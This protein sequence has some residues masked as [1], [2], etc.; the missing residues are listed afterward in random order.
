M[1]RVV[2]LAVAVVLGGCLL[3]VPWSQARD[4]KKAEKK[5]LSAQEFVTKASA[6]GLAEVNLSGLAKDRASRAEVKHFAE[7]MVT[8]HTKANAELLQL[9]NTKSLR[10]AP[11]M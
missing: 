9:A 3:A 4:E 10:V 1:R 6:A 2:S 5:A 7:H 8:D 11:R